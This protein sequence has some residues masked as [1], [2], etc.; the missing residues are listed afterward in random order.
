M[1]I[2]KVWTVERQVKNMVA[3]ESL[4]TLKEKGN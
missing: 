2:F 4:T 3:A 1:A